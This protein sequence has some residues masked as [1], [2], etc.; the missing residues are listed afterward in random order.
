LK[1]S[2]PAGALA[3]F[4]SSPEPITPPKSKS[5][6]LSPPI[7]PAALLVANFSKPA[8]KSKP[9]SAFSGLACGASS[10]SFLG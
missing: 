2:P 6:T 3:Y 7:P 4:L 1:S 10:L 9:P 8:P 5:F